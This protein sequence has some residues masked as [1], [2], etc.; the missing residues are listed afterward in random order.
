VINLFI[1]PS[2]QA[3][4]D[5]VQSATDHGYQ[6]IHWIEAGNS[7]W[8]VSDLNGKELLQFAQLIRD[9]GREKLKANN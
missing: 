4:T 6:I 8:A 5:P 3:A 9:A 7:Y 1:W 2:E